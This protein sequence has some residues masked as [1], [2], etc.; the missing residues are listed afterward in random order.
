MERNMT[1]GSP[2]GNLLRFALPVFAGNLF[3]QIYT[4]MDTVIVGKFVSTEALAAVGST[5]SISFMILG[6]VMGLMAGITVL[7]SQRFGAED[8]RGMR[9]S[10]VSAVVIAAV[11]SLILT[12]GSMLGM[13]RILLFMNTPEDIF[14]DAW[15]YIMILCAGLTA[16]AFYNLFAS[17]LRAL[18]NSKVPLYF[19]LFS[20]SLNIV[21]D[22]VMIL[23]F[24][25][26]VAGAAWATV[27]SQGLAAVLCLVYLVKRVPVLRPEKEDLRLDFRTV[28]NQ[29][30][31]GLPMAFQYSITAVG[32]AMVQS[33]LNTLGSLYVA[34]F[35]AASKTEQMVGQAYVALGTAIATF[36]AQNVGAGR[37]DRVREGFRTAFWC[38][39]V[40]SVVMGVICFFWGHM[41]TGL[42]VSEHVGQVEQL[43]DIY[44]KITALFLIPL[45]IVNIYRNGI[46]GMGYGIM[47]MMA[48]VA[49]LAGR[50]VVAVA[51][52]R[53]HSYTGVCMANPAAWILAS[54]L[55]LVLYRSVMKKACQE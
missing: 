30:G 23:V 40:F 50:G 33:S 53:F 7:T 41:V 11:S 12:V 8:L 35:T 14:E 52:S 25:A 22:L 47:P 54:A 49:E 16:Q 27:I 31:M 21:L 28:K 26:G 5:G 46:Q 2:A 3:Q 51:A 18:G 37:Y 15:R 29:L 44:M 48:G 42:F 24:R 4:V 32:S 55:L 34:A 20:A 19:L 38:G 17:I 6:F 1:E 39:A 10:V 36:A 45:A 43:I 9:R 13:R